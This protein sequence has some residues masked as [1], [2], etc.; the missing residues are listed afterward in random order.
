M[1]VSL[2]GASAQSSSLCLIPAASRHCIDS[3]SSATRTFKSSFISTLPFPDNLLSGNPT[4]YRERTSD[5]L[6]SISCNARTGPNGERDPEDG[7]T[8]A[9]LL[10]GDLERPGTDDRTA[11]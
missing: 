9:A 4:A 2:A 10:L 3:V 7:A 1:P 6:A 5:R 11:T 8:G